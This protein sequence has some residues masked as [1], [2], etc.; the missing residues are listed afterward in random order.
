MVGSRNQHFDALER[1]FLD[2]LSL[3]AHFAGIY[4][5]MPDGDFFYVNRSDAVSPDGFRTKIIDHPNGVKR[6]RMVWRDSDGILVT[7]TEDPND[8][9]DPAAPVVSKSLAE[10][11]IIWTDPY[12]F[13]H[14]KT[15]YYGGRADLRS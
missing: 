8:T 11:D 3:Y 14:H 4:I 9:F 12:I 5:G 6:T 10:R 15:R 2:Q 1:Y 7:T 13:S